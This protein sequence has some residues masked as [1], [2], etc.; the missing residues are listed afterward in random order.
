MIYCDG[1]IIAMA[2]GDVHCAFADGHETHFCQ[3][4]HAEYQAWMGACLAEEERLN[5]LLSLFLAESRQKLSLRMVP[6]D[7][8]PIRRVTGGQPLVLG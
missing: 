8:P 2:P 7:L 1:C 4:C 3:E 6:Q 5:R